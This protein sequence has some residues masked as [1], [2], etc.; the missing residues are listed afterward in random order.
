M[1]NS[2]RYISQKIYLVDN[3]TKYYRLADLPS[4][5]TPYIQFDSI[6]ECDYYLSLL[7]QG[8]YRDLEIHKSYVLQEAFTKNGKK[9]NEITYESDFSYYDTCF[10]RYRVIDVKGEILTEEFNLKR[11]LFEYKYPDYNLEVLRYSQTTG[12]VDYDDYKKMMKIKK[13]E[14]AEEKASKIVIDAINYLKKLDAMSKNGKKITLAQRKKATRE[15]ANIPPY[16]LE[17]LKSVGVKIDYEDE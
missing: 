9:Y 1:S 3:K 11:K 17:L 14:K 15:K 8:N 16:Q 6:T 12:W 2:G 4:K 10:D 7:Y 13:K 5:D